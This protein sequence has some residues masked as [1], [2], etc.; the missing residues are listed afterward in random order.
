V[1]VFSVTGE[2]MC[3][4]AKAPEQYAVEARETVMVMSTIQKSTSTTERS[5]MMALKRLFQ[6][7]PYLGVLPFR[8]RAASAIFFDRKF[9]RS[10]NAE[11]SAKVA[12][13]MHFLAAGAFDGRK[14]HPLFDPAFYLE[15]YP[16]V[17]ETGVN[18]LLHFIRYGAAEGRKP[19]PLFQP[20]YYLSR[21]PE[22]MKPGGNPLTHFLRSSPED[23]A[24]PHL[25]F[26]CE[27]YRRDHPELAA[28]GINPLV[29]YVLT[30][31]DSEAGMEGTCQFGR[32]S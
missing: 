20:D 27:S 3:L 18:P 21:C 8:T 32:H 22:A 2:K 17:R 31:R 29:H 11:F 15:R 10:T 1:K 26:D 5:F 28:K 25:L 7:V 6:V 23:C 13:L 24:S 14:P 19:C 12:P 9:Y 16:D 30:R 4:Q